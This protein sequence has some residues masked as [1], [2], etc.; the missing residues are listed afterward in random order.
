VQS[1][2]RT[3][4]TPAAES[5]LYSGEGAVVEAIGRALGALRDAERLDPTLA[6]TRGLV[7]S[8]LAELEEA[9]ASLGRYVQ[10]LTPEPAR[11]DGI[12]ERLAQRP[13]P[14]RK[15]ASTSTALTPHRAEMTAELDALAGAGA[16][17]AALKQ[18]A[19]AP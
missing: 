10:T 19:P 5:G 12:E 9:G 3:T 16:A 7:E 17:T 11:L 14:R 2:R 13:R 15:D 4:L 1:A 6:N 8:A 18:A